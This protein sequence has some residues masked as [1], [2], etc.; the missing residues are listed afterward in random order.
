[1]LLLVMRERQREFAF[2]GKRWFDL[3]RY[4]LYTSVDGTTVKMLDDTKFLDKKYTANQEQYRAK[5]GTINSLFYPIAKREMDTN[6]LLVQNEAYAIENK[7][8]KN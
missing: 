5:M 6:P 2:E 8:E 3:V 1:M 7:Y 4:A